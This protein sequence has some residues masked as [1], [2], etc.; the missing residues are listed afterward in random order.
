M[1]YSINLSDKKAIALSQHRVYERSGVSIEAGL[2][3]TYNQNVLK[4]VQFQMF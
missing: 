2:T 4:Y 3:F 1:Q